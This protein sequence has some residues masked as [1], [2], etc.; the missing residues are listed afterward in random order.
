M[1]A[2][3]AILRCLA[4]DKMQRS[5][6]LVLR[7][8][9]IPSPPEHF[10]NS[11]RKWTS[12]E[13]AWPPGSTR[14][15]RKNCARFA[16]SKSSGAV[17]PTVTS[18]GR[19]AQ[20]MGSLGTLK[21]PVETLGRVEQPGYR[22]GLRAALRPSLTFQREAAAR[23]VLPRARPHHPGHS[24][25][26]RGH[27]GDSFA[28]KLYPGEG[29]IERQA[30]RWRPSETPRSVES[31]FPERLEREGGTRGGGLLVQSEAREGTGERGGQGG[32]RVQDRE[33][34]AE[35]FGAS[36]SERP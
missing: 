18:L 32:P 23:V 30:R 3:G 33:P 5:C 21:K 13:Q 19:G 2:A 25:G 1:V 20:G 8:W 10:Q 31:P 34:R 22:P 16:G 9:F 11:R 26:Q 14:V 7:S 35:K 4:V 36:L 17:A 24:S 28:W 6:F 27:P 29:E 15:C 12:L